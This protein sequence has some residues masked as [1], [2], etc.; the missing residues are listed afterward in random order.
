MKVMLAGDFINTGSR[1][2]AEFNVPKDKKMTVLFCNYPFES[3]TEYNNAQKNALKRAFNVEK[4][5]D[6][7]E[8][9]DFADKIDIIFVN[10]GYG[11]F[12]TVKKFVDFQQ[13]KKIIE[14]VKNG[15]IYIGESTGSLLAC[16]FCYPPIYDTGDG[17]LLDMEEKYK[18]FKGLNFVDK[19]LIVHMSKYRFPKNFVD[20]NA[21]TYRII[22][23]FSS[24]KNPLKAGLKMMHTLRQKQ[25]P[26]FSIAENEV[27]IINGDRQ[28]KKSL[29]WNHLPV[30]ENIVTS[31]EKKIIASLK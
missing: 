2:C 6:L 19:S 1:L 22:N 4:I 28:Y 3:G 29:K 20:G 31:A 15:A 7:T 17:L 26:Y 27:Y 12:N 10:G 30:K 13:D 16:N 11:I 14:L 5:I 24:G 23:R 21:P 9:C 18:N 25:I 8:D